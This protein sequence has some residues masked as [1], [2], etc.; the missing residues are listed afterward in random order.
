MSWLICEDVRVQREASAES[1]DETS[2]PSLL[3]DDDDDDDNVS[4]SA[5]TRSRPTAT[6]PPVGYTSSS[7]STSTPSATA[8]GV[9]HRFDELNLGDVTLQQGGTGTRTGGGQRQQQQQGGEGALTEGY[10]SARESPLLNANR[11][12]P[13]LISEGMH[14]PS[15]PPRRRRRLVRHHRRLLFR[16]RRPPRHAPSRVPRSSLVTPF[17]ALAPV[18]EPAQPL[19]NAAAIVCERGRRVV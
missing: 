17:G 19:P 6:A 9:G 13:Q 14:S 4:L 12:R 11:S 1:N 10:D 15:K 8:A 16:L 2:S 18:S 3:E 5:P 7:T